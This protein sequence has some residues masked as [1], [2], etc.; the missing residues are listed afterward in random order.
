MVTWANL[1]QGNEVSSRLLGGDGG[2]RIRP[3][4]TQAGRGISPRAPAQPSSSSPAWPLAGTRA[5]KRESPGP[6]PSP[7]AGVSFRLSFPAPTPLPRVQ[8]LPAV[9]RG[10]GA[11]RMSP[12]GKPAG[13]QAQGQPRPPACT[14]RAPDRGAC[15]PRSLAPTSSAGRRSLQ[16]AGTHVRTPR[17]PPTHFTSQ[18]QKDTRRGSLLFLPPLPPREQGSRAASPPAAELHN[19]A[20]DACPAAAGAG[21]FTWLGLGPQRRGLHGPARGWETEPRDAVCPRGRPSLMPARNLAALCAVCAQN[22]RGERRE[23][24]PSP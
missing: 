12:H 11:G 9:G 2:G 5:L 6:M 15:A 7:E 16:A 8:E 24:C 10:R 17:L 23:D 22:R 20:G 19:R 21:R 18:A 13:G 14:L 1:P 3:R 4:L